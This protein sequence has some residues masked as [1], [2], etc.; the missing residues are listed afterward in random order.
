[1]SVYLKIKVTSLAAEAI[2][3][4]TRGLK[5]RRRLQ[6]QSTAIILPLRLAVGHRT[7]NSVTGVRIP[8]REPLPKSFRLRAEL[9]G[10]TEPVQRLVDLGE[11]QR[12][13]TRSGRPLLDGAHAVRQD[14][15]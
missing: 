14:G 13:L 9:G 6:S 4:L 1:M 7:L 11:R 2:I 3:I 5:P 12:V 8:E 10:V 15:Q